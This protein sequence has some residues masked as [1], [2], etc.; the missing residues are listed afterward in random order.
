VPSPLTAY[1]LPPPL[2][3]DPPPPAYTR[4]PMRFMTER[5]VL[6]AYMPGDAER[7]LKVWSDPDVQELIF[8]GDC[9]TPLT[10][11]FVEQTLACWLLPP[12]FLA[13]IEDRKTGAFVGE[14][15]LRARSLDARDASVGITIAEECRGRGYG[16]EVLR[17]LIDFGFRDMGLCRI[18]L[19]V[20][21]GNERALALYRKL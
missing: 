3:Y 18:H 21:E 20:F 11:D 6:R 8:S 1:H 2:G 14:V 17:W 19:H 15:G 9:P 16:R 5:T 10:R 4:T 12:S 7:L 13:I